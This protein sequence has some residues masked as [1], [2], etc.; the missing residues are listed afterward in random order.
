MTFRQ[1]EIFLLIVRLGTVSAAANKLGITQSGAS[2]TL[3]ELESN[4][5]FTLFFR[6]G[7]GIELTQQGRQFYTHVEK[8]FKGKDALEEAV[9]QIRSGVMRRIR[10]ACLHTLST[11]VLPK[12]LEQFLAVFPD[13]SIH[14]ETLNYTESITMLKERRVD[15]MLSF[16]MPKLDG[17]TVSTMAETQR[18]FAVRAE[19]PLSQLSVI[20]PDDLDGFEVLGQIP[21]HLAAVGQEEVFTQRESLLDMHHKRIWCHTS[22]TRYAMVAA[23]VAVTIAEPFAAPLFKAQGVV[24]RPFEPVL[25]IS[26]GF[27]AYSDIWESPEIMCMRHALQNAFKRFAEQENLPMTCPDL[28]S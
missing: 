24:T 27:A 28:D 16:Q 10:L 5:G 23:G 8:Q 17:I 26:Y 25:P 22:T 11:A 18:V 12:A 20:T 6:S 19:H 14:I 9:S 1:L 15:A 7:R 4:V 2:K 21:N 3:A 13:T